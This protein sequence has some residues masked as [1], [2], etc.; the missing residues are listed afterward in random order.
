MLAREKR[1]PA[2]PVGAGA[3][4]DGE[5]LTAWDLFAEYPVRL[6]RPEHRRLRL[7]RRLNAAGTSFRHLTTG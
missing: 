3:G 4:E 6:A 1:R 5:A 2:L 7:T